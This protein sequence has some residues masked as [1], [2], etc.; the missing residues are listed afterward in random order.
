MTSLCH[1]LHCFKYPF[2]NYSIS[3]NILEATPTLKCISEKGPKLGSNV[4]QTWEMRLTGPLTAF[5]PNWIHPHHHWSTLMGGHSLCE[6]C[7]ICSPHWDLL[8]ERMVEFRKIDSKAVTIPQPRVYLITYNKTR[9]N[10][11]GNGQWSQV[12]GQMV[13]ITLRCTSTLF[14]QSCMLVWWS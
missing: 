11:Q 12:K 10:F 5:I 1:L 13:K 9:H 3:W 2:T 4:T 14:G 7:Y 8:F 6:A